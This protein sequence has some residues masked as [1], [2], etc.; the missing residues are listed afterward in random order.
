VL[1]NLLNMFVVVSVWQRGHM[2]SVAF[3]VQAGGPIQFLSGTTF[4]FLL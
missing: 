2:G 4:I 1:W 3:V